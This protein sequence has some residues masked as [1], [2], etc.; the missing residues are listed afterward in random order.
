MLLGFVLNKKL[1]S[2]S[3]QF[4][5]LQMLSE[6]SCMF[7]EAACPMPMGKSH[8]GEKSRHPLRSVSRSGSRRKR[9]AAYR[10]NLALSEK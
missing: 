6:V 5:C 7:E 10:P 1:F 2:F 3:V 8:A 9:K 4:K